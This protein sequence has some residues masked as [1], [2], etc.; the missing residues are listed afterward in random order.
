[1]NNA[2]FRHRLALAAA[3]VTFMLFVGAPAEA[4]V[5]N[6][7]RCES[8]QFRPVQCPVPGIV[9]AS[10]ASVI[11]GDCRRGNWGW[12]RSGV[13]VNNGCRAIFNAITRGG[14]SFPGGGNP[15]GGFPGGGFP[16][17]GNPG[18]GQIVRCESWQFQP[19]RCGANTRGGIQ[20]Q[21]VIAGN[22]N[23]GNWGWDRNSVWVTNGCRA[24][25]ISGG[26]GGGGWQGGNGGQLVSCNSINYR[27]A[28]CAV[29]VESNVQID[30]VLGGECI[31]GRSW[32]WD[33]GG[34]WVNDGCR[35]RFRVT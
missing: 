21:R 16:S 10:I 30:R 34:I 28:R 19:A 25:F 29:R 17:S 2:S 32:G 22:C 14:G 5:N 15:G 12:D 1:M 35:A 13:R 7:I 20:I 9:D 26:N 33:R 3:A 11:A 4:Q 8:W 31:M 24:D 27:P 23:A 18:G 6:R